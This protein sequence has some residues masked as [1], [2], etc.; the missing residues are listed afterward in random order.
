MDEP[1]HPAPRCAAC[2]ASRALLLLLPP[3]C[4]MQVRDAGG[5]LSVRGPYWWVGWG[6]APPNRN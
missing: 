6:S 1:S 4:L 2:Q 5:R 3:G